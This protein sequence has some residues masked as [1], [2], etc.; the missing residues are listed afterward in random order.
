MGVR[1]AINEVTKEN[2]GY[3][4]KTYRYGLDGKVFFF[5]PKEVINQ[6]S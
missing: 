2:H 4:T 1:L 6:K 5:S 3:F